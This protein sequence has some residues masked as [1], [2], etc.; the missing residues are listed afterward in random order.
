ALAPA[1]SRDIE[2][3]QFVDRSE[4]SPMLFERPYFLLP[5]SGLIK[6]YRLLTQVL[7]AS[8]RAG[9]ATFVMRG[10]QHIVAIM[11]EG[12]LLRAQTLRFVEQLRTPETIGLPAP[13]ARLD[14][15]KVERLRSAIHEHSE[16]DIDRH[17]L[18]DDAR[19]RAI[20]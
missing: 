13:P 1:A 19:E 4:L 6:P 12:Q 17:E 5:S 18:D 10:H 16:A 2:L 7:E 8:K 20:A 9:I 11:A 14:D 3:R 15:A